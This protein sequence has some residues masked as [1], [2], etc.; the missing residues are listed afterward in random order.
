MVSLKVLAVELIAT[1]MLLW[2]LSGLL[3]KLECF[4]AGIPATRTQ[5]DSLLFDYI[6]TFYNPSRLHSSLDYQSPLQYENSLKS[7]NTQKLINNSPN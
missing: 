5:A 3:L 2:N 4:H 7:I 6:E 1:I